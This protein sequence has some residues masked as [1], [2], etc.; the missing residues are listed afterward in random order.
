LEYVHDGTSKVRRDG[1]L[2]LFRSGQYRIE[3]SAPKNNDDG[4]SGTEVGTNR[5]DEVPT[6]HTRRTDIHWGT[7]VTYNPKEDKPLTVSPTEPDPEEESL[8]QYLIGADTGVQSPMMNFRPGAWTRLTVKRSG[9]ESIKVKYL[10]L[11]VKYVYRGVDKV[12]STV[13]VRVAG[14][15]QP[16]I[17][18]SVEDGNQRADGV[19]SFLRTF[20]KNK[21]EVTLTAPLRY[22]SR[23]FRGWRTGK[24]AGEEGEVL[25][26][27]LKLGQS[28]T[29]QLQKSPDYI[30]EPVF[31]AVNYVPLNAKDEAW[32]ACPAGWVFDDWIFVNR[33]S[34]ELILQNVYLPNLD[35]RVAAAVNEPQGTAQ[36]KL[37]FERL[38]L[39]PGE[40]TKIS[41]C[42]EKAGQGRV[43]K[44]NVAFEWQTNNRYL[45]G[46]D[47]NGLL[48]V[49]WKGVEERGW[50]N[51]EELFDVDRSNRVIAFARPAA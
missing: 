45:V 27:D 4:S 20:M 37:S 42:T 2:Y 31:A 12:Y 10:I 50:M 25:D 1:R 9:D 26:K 19:G 33:T 5:K 49:F 24:G 6:G 3:G 39:L 22:G 46:F 38:K 43:G 23:A 7:R 35:Q 18:C 14:D 8:M 29:L 16:Y 48:A 11:N 15:A 51:A 17:R 32:P 41:V 28:L 47:M 13:G 44:V 30:V 34:S 36:V 21:N 40:S